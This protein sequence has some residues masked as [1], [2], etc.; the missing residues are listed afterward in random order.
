MQFVDYETGKRAIQELQTPQM[1]SCRE[2]DQIAGDAITKTRRVYPR[3]HHPKN[4]GSGEFPG[5]W[6]PQPH[7]HRIPCRHDEVVF[8][9]DNVYKCASAH[10]IDVSRLSISGT[11]LDSRSRSAGASTT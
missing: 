3:W 10:R 11:S 1:K 5:E 2:N 4:W 7:L 6:S 8:P 9:Q